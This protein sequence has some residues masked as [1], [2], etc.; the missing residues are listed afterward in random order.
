MTRFLDLRRRLG[1]EGFTPAPVDPDP[2]P[3]TAAVLV[4]QHQ[5]ARATQVT[6]SDTL[7]RAIV[8]K[9]LRAQRHAEKES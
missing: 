1:L 9:V 7:A 2:V 4:L 5:I 3:A 8:L 6:L